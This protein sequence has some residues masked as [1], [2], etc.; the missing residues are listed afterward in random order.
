MTKIAVCGAGAFGTALAMSLAQADRDVTLVAR[1]PDHASAINLDRQNRARLPGFSLPAN[2]VVSDTVSANTD[3]CL[4]AIPTQV[5]REFVTQHSEILVPKSLVACC[6]GIELRTGFTPTR[7]VTDVLAGSSVSILSGPGFARDIAKGLPTAMTIAAESGEQA[8]WLQH[9]LSTKNLR[10]YRSEDVVGVELGGA[11]KNVAAIAA[12]ITIGANLG[13]SARSALITRGFSEMK[14]LAKQLGGQPDTLSGLS[15]LGDLILTCT[16][17]QS[18]NFEFGVALG[19]GNKPSS[20]VTTEGA[21]T[22]I[23][24]S[25]LAKSEQLDMPITHTVAALLE[26]E[27]SVETAI[28]NLMSRPLKEE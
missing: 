23:A 15:G 3:I 25:K 24:V 18:R 21:A 20:G 1:T 17:T 27:I 11:L 9:L 7:I 16:S 22:A 5:L 6:K 10:L 2:L 14:A 28:S 26:G 19:Q 8:S 4:L 13:D 12:G